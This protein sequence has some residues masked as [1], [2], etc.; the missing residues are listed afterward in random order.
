M[1]TI[2]V[3]SRN[4][5]DTKWF[6]KAIENSG[7]EITGIVSSGMLGIDRLAEQYALERK[8]PIYRFTMNK[9]KYGRSADI[10]R[11]LQMVNVADAVIAIW[12]GKAYNAGHILNV[13]YR[14]NLRIYVEPCH[15]SKPSR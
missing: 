2:I 3:G 4:H 11:N 7:F 13:A 15:T 9:K 5:F 6:H 14:N 10:M 12:D 8:L 1:K